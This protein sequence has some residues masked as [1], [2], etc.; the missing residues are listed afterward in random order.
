MKPFLDK[1]LVIVG[2]K[3]GLSVLLSGVLTYLTATGKVSTQTA[4]I[5]GT[6][7]GALGLA[8]VIHSNLKAKAETVD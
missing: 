5:I 4:E 3:R 7:A 2:G 1:L 8:G 6:V